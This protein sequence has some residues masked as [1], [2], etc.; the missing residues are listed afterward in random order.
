MRRVLREILIWI[1]FTALYGVTGVSFIILIP[2][3][4][5]CFQVVLKG[6]TRISVEQIVKLVLFSS[7]IPNNYIPIAVVTFSALLFLVGKTTVKQT[8]FPPLLI[9]IT[10]LY[11]IGNALASS[12]PWMNILFSCIYCCAIPASFYMFSH[13]EITA[14][15]IEKIKDWLKGIIILQVVWLVF[16]SIT[17]LSA[18]LHEP[19]LDW[20]SGTFGYKQGNILFIVCAFASIVFL[21]SYS[22]QR[23]ISDLV[24]FIVSLVLA[25]STG[26]IGLCALYLMSFMIVMLLHPKIRIRHKVVAV[27][28]PLISIAVIY[29][30]NPSWV[31]QEIQ[32]LSNFEAV[33]N[34]IE[35]LDMYRNVFITLPKEDFLFSLIGIGFGQGMSRAGMTCAGIYISSYTNLFPTYSSQFMQE[36][37]LQKLYVY[38]SGKGGMA[39]APFS[40]IISIKTELGLVGLILLSIFFYYLFKKQHQPFGKLL[41]TFFVAILFWDNYLEYAKVMI[42]FAS[43]YYW[44]RFYNCNSIE[45]R[46]KNHVIEIKEV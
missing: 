42:V 4:L 23:Q 43:A 26:S 45:K 36:H 24:F 38:L 20:V 46:L 41:V 27:L 18:I 35:K 9:I 12:S 28:V 14:S 34:R 39:Q 29:V 10:G 32:S 2:F 15:L 37:V 8:V 6:I 3:L 33:T 22:R 5:L 40:S 16:Y 25:M 19:D 7:I 31:I 11:I 13:I 17:H 30:T 21:Y 1:P 44:C